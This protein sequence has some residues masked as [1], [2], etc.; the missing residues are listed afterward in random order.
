MSRVA[1]QT[2][3][4]ATLDDQLRQREQLIRTELLNLSAPGFEWD[5]GAGLRIAGREFYMD[6]TDTHPVKQL[7][8]TIGMPYNFFAACPKALNETIFE[9]RLRGEET[10]ER[11]VRF[12]ETPTGHKL[13]ALLDPKHTG[14]SYRDVIR[15]MLDV[16]PPTAI[17]RYA[18][19]ASLDTDHRLHLRVTLPEVAFKMPHSL[20]DGRADEL[21]LG[22]FVDTS[23]DGL[24]V[25]KMS[26]VLWRLICANGAMISYETAPLLEFRYRGV[27]KFAIDQVIRA[28]V[29]RFA[30]DVPRIQR[31][32]EDAASLSL[33]REQAMA[34]IKDARH[35]VKGMSAKFV[36]GLRKELAA[37]REQVSRWDVI[38][39]VTSAA[40]SLPYEQQI[41]AEFAAG[42]LLGLDLP[43]AA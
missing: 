2:T 6:P 7:C 22:L 29:E 34:Y 12:M 27:A 30:E 4:L 1:L 19:G 14:P 10:V 40:K 17:V 18:N 41:N 9:T 24:G 37:G 39:S 13:L 32:C 26:P 31:A 42:K 5:G 43:M 33:S 35:T 11:K 28:A 20:P 21:E 8:K 23:E 3:T 15:P 16:L 36:R 38:N 25:M